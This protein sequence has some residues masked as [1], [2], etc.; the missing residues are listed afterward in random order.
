MKLNK[1]IQDIKMEVDTI[2]KKKIETTLEK[3]TL[4]RNQET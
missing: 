4:G 3:E 1:I 2:K